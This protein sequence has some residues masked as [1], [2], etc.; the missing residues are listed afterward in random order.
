MVQPLTH[1]ILR[2]ETGVVGHAYGATNTPHML[3]IDKGGTLVYAGA[4]DNSPDAE[5]ESSEGGVLVSYGPPENAIA[6]CCYSPLSVN[7]MS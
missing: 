3:V 6:V 7:V 1:P 2:D 4:V 5:G